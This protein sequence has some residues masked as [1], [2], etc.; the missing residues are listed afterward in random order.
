MVARQAKRAAVQ[1]VEGKRVA[2]HLAIRLKKRFV[3]GL[4]LRNLWRNNWGGWA[5]H[6]IKPFE[7]TFNS[8]NPTQAVVEHSKIL[9]R[10][11]RRA[12]R[13]TGCHAV[14]KAFFGLGQ[15]RMMHGISLNR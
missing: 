10:G 11:H 7:R 2:Q 4:K 14:I 5:K 1:K 9:L 3:R 15:T 6:R 13:N 12:Q 8:C